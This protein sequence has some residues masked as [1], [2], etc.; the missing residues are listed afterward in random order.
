MAV[1]WGHLKES[2]CRETMPLPRQF[3]VLFLKDIRSKLPDSDF[4]H[5]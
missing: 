5:S 1:I 2:D 4:I 3:S